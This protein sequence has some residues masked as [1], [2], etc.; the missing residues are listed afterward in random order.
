[1]MDLSSETVLKEALAILNKLGHGY[2]LVIEDGAN[3]AIFSNGK[4]DKL[5]IVEK[6]E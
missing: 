4:D 2:M 3:V 1:M 6:E 5:Y